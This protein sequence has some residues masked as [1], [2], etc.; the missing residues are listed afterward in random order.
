M[1]DVCPACS[2]S[3]LWIFHEQAD[4]PVHS[5]LL[6]AD[7]EEARR[8]PRGDLR[9]GFCGDCGFITNTAFDPTLHS[10]STRYEETQGCSPRFQRFA[11]DLAAQWVERYA[12]RDKVVVEIG[13]GKGEFLEL[14]CDVGGNEG[15]GI[16]PSY[17]PGRLDP[18]RSARITF[19]QDFYSEK[20]GDL[21]ADAIICRHTLEHIHPV[22]DFMRTL[23]A[24][25]GDRT[26]T[27]VLFE[28]PDVLR[29]LRET[30][31]WDVYYEHCSYF[32]LGS[33]A[34][35]FRA[36]GFEVLDLS[37]AFDDQYLLLEARPGESSHEPF[38]VEDDFGALAEAVDHF[39]RTFA[40][41]TAGWRDE[42]VG[43][44][45]E[46]RRAVIWG[47]GSK[48]VAY[49]TTLGIT[50]EIEY[51]VDI[52]PR[53]Q[54]MFMAG[55]GHPIVGPDFLRDYRPDLVVVM[56]AIYTEEIRDHLARL[57]LAPEVVAV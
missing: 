19:V 17:V 30:A 36:T 38:A 16:D 26:D 9:L 27:I 42:L 41:Q 18:G 44:V 2:A 6:L 48:G 49:L 1:A 40:S 51:V 13:C 53:K 5:C 4:L 8:F 39:Q 43:A 25:I 54:G 45:K 11:K 31:F 56:N 20:Y 21:A 10:Y 3:G 12:L 37:L 28:L 55:S 47:S 50:D 35:L 14:V 15:I 23:R 24:S 33:L 57:G 29:V 34:R 22:A 52:N 32:S 7:R 46:G